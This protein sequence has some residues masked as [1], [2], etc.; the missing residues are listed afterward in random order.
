MNNIDMNN[1]DKYYYGYV[2]SDY[3]DSLEVKIH[4]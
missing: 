3:T 1:L 2:D 4:T